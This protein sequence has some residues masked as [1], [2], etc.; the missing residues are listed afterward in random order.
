MKVNLIF[1]IQIWSQLKIL[2]LITS[3]ESKKNECYMH[4][5]IQLKC[6]FAWIFNCIFKMH[7]K[8][9]L[10]AF[11]IIRASF[12]RI[13]VVLVFLEDLLNS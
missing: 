8:M 7:V 6:I 4:F 11:P 5:K 9:H 2:I 10:N 13:R 12:T 1:S 3:V